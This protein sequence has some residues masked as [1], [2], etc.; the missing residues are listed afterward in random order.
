MHHPPSLQGHVIE[1]I[2][3]VPPALQ[4]DDSGAVGSIPASLPAV[5]F[6]IRKLLAEP[7]LI[8]GGWSEVTG[9]QGLGSFGVAL[10]DPMSAE[11]Q[12]ESVSA[13]WGE[14]WRKDVPQH[15]FFTTRR[16]LQFVDQMGEQGTDDH[17]WYC[18]FMCLVLLSSTESSWKVWPYSHTDSSC[19]TLSLTRGECV[20]L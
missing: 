9:H 16:S 10:L 18:E 11:P 17:W 7:E 3:T 20:S 4:L 12:C 2:H 8:P 19:H 14:G 5:G 6:Y 13:V 1:N 15:Y